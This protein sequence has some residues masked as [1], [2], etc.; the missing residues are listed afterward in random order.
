VYNSS[1]HKFQENAF[2]L[3]LDFCDGL[4]RNKHR[5]HRV[6]QCSSDVITP[7]SY[8]TPLAALQISFPL[9]QNP[10]PTEGPL[11]K[12]FA[13]LM[14]HCLSGVIDRGL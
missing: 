12:Q 5:F 4:A 9:I 13:K 6:A 14:E 10:T 3:I 1:F 7:V 2:A 11:R 8:E